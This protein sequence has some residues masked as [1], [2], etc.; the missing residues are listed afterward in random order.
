VLAD[1]LLS[2]AAASQLNTNVFPYLFFS[3]FQLL[4]ELEV[5]SGNF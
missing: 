1:H 4:G 3:G 5:L 2:L